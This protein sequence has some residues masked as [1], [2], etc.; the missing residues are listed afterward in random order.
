M[1]STGIEFIKYLKSPI[2]AQDVVQDVFLK[3]WFERNSI[4]QNKPL[5][6]WLYTVA[7]HNIL[8]KLRKIANDWKAIDNIAYTQLNNIDNA[9]FKLLENEYKR[10]LDLALSQL[11]EQQRLA[12]ALSRNE[13]FSYFK[14]INGVDVFV[15]T[16]SPAPK[17][18]LYATP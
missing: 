8:N 7:K 6:A 15:F 10:H 11:S 17:S 1:I 14:N 3:L 9:D 18:K 5:E 16:F 12:F 4:I 2:I 13:K